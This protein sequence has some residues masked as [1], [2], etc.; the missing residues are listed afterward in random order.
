MIEKITSAQDLNARMIGGTHTLKKAV[1]IAITISITIFWSFF[2]LDIINISLLAAG[3]GLILARDLA[4]F[5]AFY[6][7]NAAIFIVNSYPRA[8]NS[9]LSHSSSSSLGLSL[10]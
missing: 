5:S 9:L 10:N 8:S 7:S 6:F 1:I 3:P 4:N 2:F